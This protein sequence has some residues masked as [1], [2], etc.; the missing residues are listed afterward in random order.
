MRH[1]TVSSSGINRFFN[2]AER[3]QPFMVGP[4]RV[5]RGTLGLQP[6]AR[7]ISYGPMA[8]CTGLEPVILA[9]QASVIAASLTEHGILMRI[10]ISIS[11]FAGRCPIHWTM[12]IWWE[13]RDSNPRSPKAP[14][15]QPGSIATMRYSHGVQNG[16]RTHNTPALNRVALPRLAYLDMVL[17]ERFELST[18]RF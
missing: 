9:R 3:A 17:R 11:S 12:R 16:I 1:D 2:W 8:L 4:P 14:G 7:P 10:R 18:P 6:S 15:L 5:E 13:Q